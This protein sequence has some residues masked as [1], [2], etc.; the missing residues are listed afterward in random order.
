[1]TEVTKE[2]ELW[3]AVRS[4]EEVPATR[5][6]TRNRNFSVVRP[7]GIG[8]GGSGDGG[9]GPFLLLSTGLDE[10]GTDFVAKFRFI[11][12]CVLSKKSGNTSK[13]MHERWNCLRKTSNGQHFQEK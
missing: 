5:S 7:R 2:V 1:L 4:W 13:Q 6:A 11:F 8:G 3:V 10:P 12:S 9:D